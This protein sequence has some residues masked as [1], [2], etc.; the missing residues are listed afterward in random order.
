MQMT[1]C[2]RGYFK[3]SSAPRVLGRAD[4]HPRTR[5]PEDPSCGRNKLPPRINHVFQVLRTTRLRV[6]ARDGLG[7]GEAEEEPGLVVED[8]LYSIG[9][10]HVAHFQRVDLLR[11]I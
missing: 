7:T 5:A 4:Y 10:V 11:G 3:G 8:Q 6:H 2:L 1:K 9:G